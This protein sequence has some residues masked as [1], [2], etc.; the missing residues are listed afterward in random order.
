VS[1]LRMALRD[2]ARMRDPRRCTDTGRDR[3]R[4]QG[5]ARIL[6]DA[7]G[8]HNCATRG[9]PLAVCAMQRVRRAIPT[10]QGGLCR[11]RS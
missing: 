2:R 3:R 7:T 11:S 1:V 9:A 5:A 8:R 4:R 10:A 6:E